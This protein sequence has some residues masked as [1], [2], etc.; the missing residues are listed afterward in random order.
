[1]RILQ[2][3]IIAIHS[4]TRVPG[5]E[6]SRKYNEIGKKNKSEIRHIATGIYSDNQRAQDAVNVTLFH[7]GIHGW[8]VYAVVGLL[9]A[10]IAYRKGLPMTIRS[11]FHPLLG[12]RIYGWMGDLI[13][14]LSVIATMFGVCTSLGIGVIT[15]NS[16]LNRIDPDIEENTDN[17]IICIWAI[18]AM[19]TVSVVTGLK[20]G[21]KY[22][23]ELCFCLGMFLMMF[24]FFYDDT[25]FLLNL[26]VQSIGYYLQWIIQLGFHTDAFA[27]LGNAP[28]GKQAPTWMD[29]WTIFYWGWWIAWSPFVGMFIAKISRGRT[30]RNF[31]N[32]TLT[33]PI[34]YS[35][36][37]FCIFGGAGLR[38]ERDAVLKGVNCSSALG[39]TNATEGLDKLYK[40][41]CRKQTQMY[42][43]VLDQYGENLSGFL[44]VVSLIAMV[45]YFVTSS[46][47]GSLIIDCL[48]ANG[49]PE[50]PVLQRIFWALTEGA[51]ATALLYTGGSKA[52][53]ALQ[54]V[55]IAGGLAY[56]IILNFMCVALWRVMKEEA[57]DNDPN[58]RYFPSSLFAVF[59]FASLNKTINVIVT[60]FAPWWLGG[61]AAGKVYGQEAWPHMLTLGTLFYGWIA[62]LILEILEDGLAYIGW[63][64]LCGFFAYTT[65]IRIRAR[66]KYEISGTM[67]EDALAVVF[68]YPLAIDQTYEAVLLDGGYGHGK[69]SHPT[70]PEIGLD[71]MGEKK[72]D[73]GNGHAAPE[74]TSF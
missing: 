5:W 50:P 34:L 25:W 22:I 54:T 42:F 19:A 67:I 16:A 74:D 6:G 36:L 45:L 23:S 55:S 37:W 58:A 65:G 8:I 59:D 27:Q 28:D 69:D 73:P 2:Y 26:Y 44:R 68:L 24:V 29:D 40:L 4:G 38:M 35:F 48:S 53:T 52:L 30:V 51:C 62:L 60:I 71:N 70:V 3:K 47:S 32:G 1:M 56:T 43:D 63:V 20:V 33:A 14:S 57:G 31:I 18:T 9:M 17:Q 13:D 64:I 12:D 46:D 10:F 11:C 21:I 39:G 15:I 41:S 66:A 7:W 61:K 72:N 49:N